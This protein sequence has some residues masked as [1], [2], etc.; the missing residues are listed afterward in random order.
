MP[1]KHFKLFFILFTLSG[2]P[3]CATPFTVSVNNQAVYD[4]DGRLARDIV[5]DADLQ[6]CINLALRQQSLTNAGELTVLSCADSEI[7][8]LE[9]IEQLGKL[10]FLDLANNS[11]SNVTPLEGLTELGSLNLINNQISDIGPLLNILSLVT[12]SLLG[13]NNI[14]C[15]QLRQMEL[16]LGSNLTPPTVCAR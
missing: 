10:R 7:D 11:I 13:N 9:N 16:R 3:A 12:V 6:G 14:P 15:D 2:L 8:D 4:P 5:T 1:F